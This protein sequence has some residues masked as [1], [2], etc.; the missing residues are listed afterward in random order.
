MSICLVLLVEIMKLNLILQFD[1]SKFFFALVLNFEHKFTRLDI[2]IDD[3]DGLFTIKQLYN[4]A[5][6]GHMTVSKVKTA[7]YF[8]EFEIDTGAT[9]GQTLYIGKT[10]Q[11]IK[12]L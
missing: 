8:E 5:K 6:K 4:K 11:I 10:N 1:W 9:M 7:R 2:A 12:V 3:F